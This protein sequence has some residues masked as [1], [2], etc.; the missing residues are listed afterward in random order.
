MKVIIDNKVHNI[1]DEFYEYARQ[2][3]TAL[4]P[5][6][7]IYKVLR[8]YDELGNLGNYAFVC[9]NPRLKKDWIAKG[10]KECIIEDFHFAFQ[11]FQDDTT[12]E[13]YVYVQDTCHS[14]LYHE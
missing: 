8:I 13:C 14:L 6:T 9:P 11:L 1:I 3:H 12:Q 2:R 5:Y 10:Y 4:D 7:I